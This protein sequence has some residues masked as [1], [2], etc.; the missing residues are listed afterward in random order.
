LTEGESPHT[1]PINLKGDNNMLKVIQDKINELENENRVL[2]END[3][4]MGGDKEI[5]EMIADNERVIGIM[6]RCFE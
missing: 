5:N 4:V 3:Y 2:E 6:R 1:Y